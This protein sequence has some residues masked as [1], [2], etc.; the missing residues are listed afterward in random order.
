MEGI[1]YY[2]S[3]C[4]LIEIKGDA[5]AIHSIHFIDE[6]LRE[7][8]IPNTC[9]IKCKQELEAYFK[10]ELK[11]FLSKLNPKGTDFQLKVWKALQEIPYGKSISYTDLAIRI[12][13]IQS[14]RAVGLANAKNPIAIMIPCHRVIGKNGDLVG[15][16]GGIDRKKYLLQ[17]EG[18]IKQQLN[19]F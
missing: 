12:G 1:G 5:N 4:G 8:E 10:G 7:N 6:D 3:P 14:V 11:I 2:S 19:I 17:Q 9:I 18:V 15:Y 13:D 16:A